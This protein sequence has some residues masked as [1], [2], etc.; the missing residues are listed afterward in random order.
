MSLSILR[1]FPYKAH[2]MIFSKRRRSTWKYLK[3]NDLLFE[4]SRKWFVVFK[5]Y[6]SSIKL[7]FSLWI[8]TKLEKTG[9]KME[10]FDNVGIS[11]YFALTQ[12]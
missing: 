9:E 2:K 11:Y 7:L 4:K 6:W 10:K 5:I 12:K 3:S 1:E 8:F